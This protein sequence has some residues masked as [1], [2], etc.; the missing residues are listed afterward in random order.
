MPMFSL[1][2]GKKAVELAR[3]VV[4]KYVKGEK[5]SVGKTPAKFNQKFGVFVTL[6]TYPERELR[7]C[8]G[9][10][11]PTLPLVN[12]LVESAQNATRD[13]RF[14]PLTTG[15]LDKIVVEVSLLT[16]PE[17]IKVVDPLEYKGKIRIGIDGLIAEKSFYR[18]ILLPQVAVEWKWNE[19]EFLTHTCLKASLAP[20]AWLDK[21]TRI[22][23]Y[24]AQVF[25]EAE[26]RGK[27]VERKLILKE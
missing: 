14:E 22:Y 25:M 4:D 23:K 24:Q 12:A 1:E 7:G 6:D 13:P 5:F 2:E 20:D 21:E 17:L 9:Y 19:E 16:P 15:E 8:I 11:E 3:A 27:V 26:P 10:P 18:G